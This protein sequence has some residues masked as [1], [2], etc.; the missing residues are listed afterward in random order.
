MTIQEHRAFVE[1]RKA[2]RAQEEID[3]EISFKL[4]KLSDLEARME[5]YRDAAHLYQPRIDAILAWFQDHDIS[6]ILED[7]CYR[8]VNDDIE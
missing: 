4:G 2:Q 1:A 8:L 6:V 7:G 3:K 5:R